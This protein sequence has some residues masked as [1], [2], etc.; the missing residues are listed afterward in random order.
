[1]CGKLVRESGGSWLERVGEVTCEGK[2][3]RRVRE[4]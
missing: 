4:K 3:M 1:M 2:Y